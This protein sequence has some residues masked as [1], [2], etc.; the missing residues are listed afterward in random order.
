MIIEE[1]SGDGLIVDIDYS[2]SCERECGHAAMT[3]FW[4]AAPGDR[5]GFF[6]H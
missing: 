3:H 1:M 4:E 5:K 6:E 2:V